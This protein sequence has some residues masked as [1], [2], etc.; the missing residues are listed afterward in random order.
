[1]GGSTRIPRV[2]ALLDEAFGVDVHEEIDPDLAVALGA[3]I[4]AAL[5]AGEAVERILVDVASHSLGVLALG[6]DEWEADTFAPIVRRNTVLPA[7]RTEEF[8]TLV[9]DQ[10]GVEV[11]VYQ[12]ESPRASQNTLVGEFYY[13]L[14]PA[15][16]H[17]PVRVEFSYTLDGI[18]QVKVL[19]KGTDN[20]TSVSLNVADAAK[21]AKS[22]SLTPAA[23]ETATSPAAPLS[24]VERKAIELA[25]T[26]PDEARARLEGLLHRYRKSEGDAREAAEEALLDFFLDHE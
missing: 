20:V 9:D 21:D 2:R 25:K 26:L 7:T 23:A 10:P 13:H 4:Q 16:A 17:T 8:Y 3:A 6:Q 12:G 22:A 24:P 1:V 14:K 11:K 19:Q 18:V 15:P 5:L